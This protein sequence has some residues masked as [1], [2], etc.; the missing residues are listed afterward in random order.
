LVR[1]ASLRVGDV[2]SG[3]E[4][5]QLRARLAAAE[6][7]LTQ[8]NGNGARAPR[9]LKCGQ[10]DEQ[11]LLDLLS[12]LRSLT[13]IEQINEESSLGEL[14]IPGDALASRINLQFFGEKARIAPDD[15]ADNHTVGTLAYLI[16]LHLVAGR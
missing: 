14:G 7:V 9:L 5:A 10:S 1:I 12:M 6:R 8:L 3:D 4:F 16:A 15:L 11:L 13:S 2:I